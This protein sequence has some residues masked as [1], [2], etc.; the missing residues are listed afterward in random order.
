MRNWFQSLLS[1]FAFTF[2][3]YRYVE[4]LR[5]LDRGYEGLDDKLIAL[6]AVI[7]RYPM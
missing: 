2:N 7:R 6:G 4:G 1:T 5:H 3:L